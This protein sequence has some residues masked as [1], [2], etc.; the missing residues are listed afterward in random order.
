MLKMA[1]LV[2][3]SIPLLLIGAVLGS[4]WCIVDVNQADGPHILVPV[5]LSLARAALAFAPDEAK[6]V[7]IPELAEY[8]D[9]A[10]Q[11]IDELADAPDGVLVEVHDGNDHVRIAKVDDELEIEVETDDEDVSIRVPLD[12]VTDVLDSYDGEELDTRDVL[13]ALSSVSRTDLVHVRTEDEEVRVWI[14]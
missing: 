12:F 11:I 4:S 5:P 7:E 6:H 13:S 8:S 9:V 10:E 3:L 14:W 2:A 1:A